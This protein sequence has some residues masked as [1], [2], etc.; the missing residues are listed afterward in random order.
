MEISSIG[1]RT[2]GNMNN[3]LSLNRISVESVFVSGDNADNHS[4]ARAYRRIVTRLCPGPGMAGEIY[5]SKGYKSISIHLPI[6]IDL[7][8][9]KKMYFCCCQ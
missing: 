9:N 1:L 2:S 3:G 8:P 5:L 4:E 6:R 7:E